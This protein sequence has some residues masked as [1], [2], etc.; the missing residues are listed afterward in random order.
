MQYT[1]HVSS[2]A[3]QQYTNLNASLGGSGPIA[4]GKWAY[5]FGVQGGRK[6]S[7]VASLLTADD[8]L[9]QHAGVS[10]DSAARFLALLGQAHIPAS[11]DGLPS[12]IDDNVSFVGRITTRRTTGT[13]SLTPDDVRRKA[14]ASGREPRPRGSARSGHPRTRHERAVARSLTAFYTSLFGPNN[15]SPMSRAGSVHAHDVRSVPSLPMAGAG[16]F[17]FSNGAAACRRFSSG[18]TETCRPTRAP[19]VGRRT[20]RCNSIR[21]VR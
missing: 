18:A 20:R 13:R 7:D 8:D 17:E 11:V 1:D 5:N 14:M 3:G 16:C 2:H 15:I 10:P 19:G 21:R 6:S 4:D 12:T 9:L